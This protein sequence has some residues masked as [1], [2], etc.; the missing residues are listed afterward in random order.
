[1]EYNL[2]GDIIFVHLLIYTTLTSYLFMSFHISILIEN[3]GIG[4]PGRTQP[5]LEISDSFD[6]SGDGFE[7]HQRH[8]GIEMTSRTGY[9]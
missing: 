1:M 5:V 7:T 4:L 2:N 8:P 3:S 6:S 9:C